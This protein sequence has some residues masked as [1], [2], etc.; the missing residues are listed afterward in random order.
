MKHYLGK[1][2]AD[3]VVI[4]QALKTALVCSYGLPTLLPI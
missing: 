2:V 4:E 1:I 3:T